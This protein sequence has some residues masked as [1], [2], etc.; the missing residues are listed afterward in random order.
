[1]NQHLA[2]R[3]SCARQLNLMTL[4][5]QPRWMVML[6][7]SLGLISTGGCQP[8]EQ[9]SGAQPICPPSA[10]SLVPKG[11]WA[12]APPQTKDHG[13]L[14]R[15]ERDGRTSWLYGT[16]HI[17]KAEW[18]PPGPRVQEA[19]LHSDVIALETDAQEVAA[20]AKNRTNAPAKNGTADFP[21]DEIQRERLARLL[22]STCI[23][24]ELFREISKMRAT[25]QIALLGLL[26]LQAEGL[27]PEF[28]SEQ[29]L[30]GYARDSKKPLTGLETFAEQTTLIMETGGEGSLSARIDAA[31]SRLES[32]KNRKVTAV[33]AD[34]W[35]RGDLK[36]L[37][38]HEDW[39][40]CLNTPE[41]KTAQER[42]TSGRQPL[43]AT[44]IEALHAQGK[45]VFVAVGAMH[46]VGPK[47]LPG[48]LQAQ[49]FQVTRVP[50]MEH[51]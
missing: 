49:G 2:G 23:S 41:E 44:R 15:V 42:L 17:G 7:C 13:F 4:C 39:C 51:R 11:G 5:R 33:I 14:W 32:G 34:T 30:I 3:H 1:M 26:A 24:D 12:S 27:Y 16:M 48:L 31:L 38:H 45:R 36:K 18:M 40:D 46:M 37:E 43:M 6:V 25:R 29:Y 28:G 21:A 10:G 8:V 9:S 50:L 35:A 22:K 20:A 19:L 47:G